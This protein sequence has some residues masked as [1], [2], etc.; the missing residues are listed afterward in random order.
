MRRAEGRPSDVGTELTNHRTYHWKWK[1]ITVRIGP[2]AIANRHVGVERAVSAGDAT[3]GKRNVV[4]AEQAEA[5]LAKRFGRGVGEVTS[6]GQGEWSNAYAFR[7]NGAALIVRFG[8]YQEDFAKDRVAAQYGSRDL[9]IPA[10]T[11]IGAA[12]DGFYAI[13]ER[14][15]GS[16]LDD[17]DAGQMRIVLPALLTALHAARQID[18][19]ATAGYGAW[20]ASGAAPH[21]SWRAAL[22][23]VANDRPTDRTHGWRERLRR[24]PT[25]IGPFDE[26]FGHLQSLV[27]VCP[28]ER[29]LIHGDLLNR[30]VLVADGGIA[31]VIDWGCSMY[32][33]FLYDL[34][35]MLYW[36]PWYPAWRGI[37]VQ[38]EAVRNYEAAGL[39]M[40]YFEERLRCCQIHIG[41]AGQAYNAFK[42]KERWSALEATAKRTLAVAKA[43]R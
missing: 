40:P 31:A 10:V 28:E 38:R 35:W 8:A 43:H 34:A 39:D 30:N 9:P 29:H 20:G 4:R 21:T 3:P 27:A 18:L 1:S 19:S 24:S 14:A 37:D 11:E 16:Y 5:F 6:A 42:G 15:F 36:S 32:G 22:L 17:L 23:D 2:C 25:G 41:L 7:R 26:A 12:F 33:D 13:S